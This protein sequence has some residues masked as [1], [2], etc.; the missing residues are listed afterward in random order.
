MAISVTKIT[1]ILAFAVTAV[2]AKRDRFL[3]QVLK[4]KITNSL[5]T[6]SNINHKLWMKYLEKGLATVNMNV[7][8]TPIGNRQKFSVL[9]FHE[10]YFKRHLFWSFYNSCKVD[11]TKA[12]TG[13]QTS[14]FG[15]ICG[16]PRQGVR[17]PPQDPCPKLKNLGNVR[18]IRPEVYKRLL[19]KAFAGK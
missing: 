12:S 18:D 14:I 5:L 11:S 13:I 8:K 10:A 2:Y 1:L 4:S 17:L 6:S 16:L 19:C 3:P 9:D 7:I 15:N